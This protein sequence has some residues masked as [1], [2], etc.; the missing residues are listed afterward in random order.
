MTLVSMRIFITAHP[1][2]PCFF[3]VRIGGEHT[4]QTVGQ[5]RNC[6]VM[7]DQAGDFGAIFHDDDFLSLLD[8]FQKFIIQTMLLREWRL[9][10]L[11]VL[12]QDM[13]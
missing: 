6:A 4:D 10:L 11:W 7:G 2:R 5:K 12:L 3:F 13:R 9:V 1:F 8:K